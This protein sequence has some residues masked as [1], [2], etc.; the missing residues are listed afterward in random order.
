MQRTSCFL[1]DGIKGVELWWW[2]VWLSLFPVK[3]TPHTAD[4]GADVVTL[5]VLSMVETTSHTHTDGF[6]FLLCLYWFWL[7]GPAWL[8]VREPLLAQDARMPITQDNALSLLPLLEDWL[9]GQSTRSDPDHEEN[10]EHQVRPHLLLLS[11]HNV[12]EP[13]KPLVFTF[14]LVHCLFFYQIHFWGCYEC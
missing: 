9:G 3:V 11:P 12:S 8:L 14:C 7:L 13:Y 5:W 1:K 2:S 6:R 4:P 10:L